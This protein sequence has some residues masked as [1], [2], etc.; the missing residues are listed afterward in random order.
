MALKA[1]PVY[2]AELAY[3]CGPAAWKEIGGALAQRLRAMYSVPDEH[4]RQR[5]LA[6]MLASGSQ[7]FK[8]VFLPLLTG[9]NDQ[10]RLGTYRTWPDF[11]V[12][13]IGPDWEKTVRGWSEEVR[14]EFVSELLHFGNARETISSF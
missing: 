3:L 4:F 8:D 12:S 14:A 2:A 5:A 6:G 7:D 13:S 10:V 1:D 11:H 9:E